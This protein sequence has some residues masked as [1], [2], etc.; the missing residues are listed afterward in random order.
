MSKKI[1]HYTINL[2]EE[3][4]EVV[5]ALAKITRRKPAELLALIIEDNAPQLL[6]DEMTAHKLAQNFTTPARFYTTETQKKGEANK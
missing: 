1:K 6:A 3:A 5:E 4:A 2:N